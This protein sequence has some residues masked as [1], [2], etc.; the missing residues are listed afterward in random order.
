MSE[1]IESIDLLRGFA[2]LGIL[3]MNISSFALPGGAYFNP[4]AWESGTLNGTLHGIMHVLADQKMMGLF[5][6][7]FGASMLLLMGK[8][9]ASG[10]RFGK[11]HYARMGWLFLFGML[12]AIFLWQGDILMVYALCGFLLF[13][14]RRLRPWLSLVL[15]LLIFLAPVLWAP[16]YH[17]G[18]AGLD[19]AGAA[20]LLEWWN[21]GPEE[22]SHEVEAMRGSYAEGLVYR[23]ED[24]AGPDPE[25]EEAQWALGLF[26][27]EA[28]C[29]A[30]GMMLVGMA[31]FRWGLLSAERS[32]R[33]YL[34]I[35]AT[36]AALGLALAGWGL[37]RLHGHGFEMA[38]GLSLDRSWNHLATPALAA[39]YMALVMLWSRSGVLAGL[40]VRLA[41]V[42]RMA[43]SNYIGQSVLCTF[44]F[45]GWGLGLFA[46][47]NRLE[48]LGV[49]LAVWAIQLLVS[50]WWLQRFR[51]GPL[52]WLWR[53]LT[54]WKPQSLR[55]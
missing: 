50:H 36:G 45:Y 39:A 32:R 48:L 19:E 20:P 43:F 40:Q 12:H 21:P 35:L 55:R 6:M 15:G 49:V 30:F 44:L 1:R 33:F 26:G 38:R 34:T 13:L 24:F 7:L 41:S 11:V 29:R 17:G 10:R 3:L 16:A 51:M 47:L 53:V 52:E 23:W 2:L 46:R 28:L 14:L 37:G 18:L 22:L 54:Y 8:V 5:S 25:S 27:L 4:L 42:G 9:E 31:L